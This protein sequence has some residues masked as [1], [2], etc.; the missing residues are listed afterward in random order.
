VSPSAPRVSNEMT[1]AGNAKVRR[2]DGSDGAIPRG[3]DPD[4]VL[5]RGD[6]SAFDQIVAAHQSRVARLAYRLLGWSEDV[7]DVVQEVFLAALKAMP[8]FKGR[9][10]LATWLT[11]ITVNQCR[12]V[13]RRRLVRLAFLR[14]SD[15][16]RDEAHHDNSP[17]ADAETFDR[18]R[19]AVLAL[20]VRYREAVVLRYLEEMPVAEVGRALGISVGAVEMRLH[21]ARARL[22]ESL[23]HVM[24][25]QTDAGRSD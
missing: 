20:P 6:D 3:D 25:E 7:D 21:R 17:T 15:A 11:T 24:E 8:R 23:Q 1:M 16:K 9:A 5:R 2:P 14:R 10:R 4:A 12:N 18:V 22:H 19:R 13:R